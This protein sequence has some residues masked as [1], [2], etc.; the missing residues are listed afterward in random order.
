MPEERKLSF[1]LDMC[2]FAFDLDPLHHHGSPIDL[3]PSIPSPEA[4]AAA[5]VNEEE[6]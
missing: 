4:A 5:A 1:Y 6:R 2:S 3:Q